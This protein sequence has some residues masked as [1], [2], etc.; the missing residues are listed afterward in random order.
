M[1]VFRVQD[2]FEIMRSIANLLQSIGVLQHLSAFL[3][4][5][6]YGKEFTTYMRKVVCNQW[7]KPL[8]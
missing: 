2:G 7:E 4:Q 6:T 5:S 8:Q 3:D 1:K